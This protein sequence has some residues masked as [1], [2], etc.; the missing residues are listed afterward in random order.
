[1][2]IASFFIS[3]LKRIM[4]RTLSL[5]KFLAFKN[6]SFPPALRP[7]MKPMLLAS[8]GLHAVALLTPLPEPPIKVASPQPKTVKLSA[9]PTLK[10]PRKLIKPRPIRKRPLAMIPPKGLIVPKLVKKAAPAA[11]PGEKPPRN[12]PPEKPALKPEK[13]APDAD[14]SDPMKDFPHYPNADAG[15]LGIDSC[16]DTKQTLA[17]VTQYFE[18]QL[19]LKKFAVKPNISEESRKVYQIDKKGSTQFLNIF[20]TGDSA[21]YALA[22]TAITLADL[23]KTVQIPP[24]FTQTVLGQLP[25]GGEAN[26]TS[27]SPEQLASPKAFYTELGGQDAQ[28]FDIAPTPNP[29]IE[30][31]KLVPNQTPEQLFSSYFSASLAK[32]DYQSKPIGAGYGGGLLYEIKKGSLKPFYLSLVPT[33]SGSGTVVAVWRSNPSEN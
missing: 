24:D 11:A 13:L 20:W 30:T 7:F 8:I 19:P 25:G 9:L 22:P 14:N 6:L 5:P 23:Q 28:K 33:K 10:V 16:Y 3:M 27:V 1:L 29:E 32:S 18:K 26:E 17:Q 15:C 31:L 2:N 21:I 12:L 4:A